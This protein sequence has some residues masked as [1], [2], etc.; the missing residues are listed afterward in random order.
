[1]LTREYIT[2][3]SLC[4]LSSFIIC[5]TRGYKNLPERKKPIVNLLLL[6]LALIL[7]YVLYSKNPAVVGAS[8]A[9]T[10]LGIL[11]ANDWHQILSEK[12]HRVWQRKNAAR[13]NLLSPASPPL[14]SRQCLLRSACWIDPSSLLR[15]FKPGVSASKKKD[16]MSAPECIENY[17]SEDK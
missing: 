9:P 15:P 6:A 8:Q 13:N 16:K 1:M 14:D 10:L 12:K 2:F 4:A 3:C 7:T 5:W 17:I 11:V